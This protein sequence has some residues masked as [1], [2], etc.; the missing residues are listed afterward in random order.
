MREPHA[1]GGDLITTVVHD[2][3]N[4]L[5]AILMSAALIGR[6]SP[7]EMVRRQVGVIQRSAERMNR[8]IL[9]LLDQASLDA[10]RLPIRRARHE[11]PALLHEAVE[12]TQSVAASKGVQIAVVPCER[13]WVDC[14]GERIQQILSNLLGNALA[15]TPTGGRIELG[16]RA[17]GSGRVE[18]FVRDDGPGIPAE[19]LP[20]VFERFWR[21]RG[22]A[23]A[24]AGLGLS[25]A[26]GIVEA[27][28][29]EISVDSVPGRGTTFRFTLPGGLD[30]RA[31]A[32]P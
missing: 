3:K 26:K 30:E 7:D 18:L 15:Y 32:S 2:L 22:A 17:L 13:C 25:I 24:N 16:A 31:E 28:G 27:H 9:E 12:L 10:G 5:N 1:E 29:G 4:P 8:L 23:R 6:A 14:D 20:H 11:V 19:E 21:G